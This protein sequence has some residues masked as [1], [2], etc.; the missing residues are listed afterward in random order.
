VP[1]RKC[2]DPLLFAGGG[3]AKVLKV[4]KDAALKPLRNYRRSHLARTGGVR[5]R[6]SR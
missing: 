3:K 2:L 6:F 4:V 1:F 5:S